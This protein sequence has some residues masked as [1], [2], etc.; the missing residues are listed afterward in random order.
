M[1]GHALDSNNPRN[2]LFAFVSQSVHNLS[3]TYLPDNIDLICLR[4]HCHQASH[5]TPSYFQATEP[6]AWPDI[7]HD[8]LTWDQHDAV[9]YVEICLKIVELVSIELEI[10]LHAGDVGI[11]DVHLVQVFDDLADAAKGHEEDVQSPHKVPLS[12]RPW[13]LGGEHRRPR[14]ELHCRVSKEEGTEKRE[15]T[16][17]HLRAFDVVSE[18]MIRLR[19]MYI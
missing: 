1:P 8:D 16:S 11:V 7:S 3:R 4:N 2:T 9:G 12:W 13:L 17:T 19:V 6:E 10:F 15:T 18:Q 14:K 5:D